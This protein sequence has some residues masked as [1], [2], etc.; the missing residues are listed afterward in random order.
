[1]TGTPRSPTDQK[2]KLIGAALVLAAGGVLA[3]AWWDLC[4]PD[5][6]VQWLHG[7]RVYAFYCRQLVLMALGISLACLGIWAYGT[8]RRATPPTQG[9]LAFLPAL[10]A[11]GFF[12]RYWLHPLGVQ[13]GS[14]AWAYWLIAVTALSLAR[15]LA[16]L[17]PTRIPR[18]HARAVLYTLIALYIATFGF[19]SIARHTTF[20]SHALDLGT[21]DQAIWNTIHGR[22]LERTPLYRHPA[23]G[24]RYESRLSDGK[25]EL[26]LIPLSALYL[27]WPDPRLL[28]AV[29]T[30][31]LAMGAV[32]L[33]LLAKGKGTAGD[34]HRWTA[35]LLAAAYLVYLPLHYINLADF[36]P[37]ALMVPL[38]IA[39][40][41]ATRRQRWQWY[42]T[43]LLLAFLCRVDAAFAALGVG[44]ALMLRGRNARKYGLYTIVA[45]TAWLTLDLGVVTPWA[46]QLYGPGAGSLIA[47]RFGNLPG[48]D[49]R[50][51]ATRLL[52]RESLQTIFD[53]LAP[54]GFVAVLAPS[55]L[56]PALPMLVINLLAGSEWQRSIHAHYMAAV[57][58]FVWIAVGEAMPRITRRF[59]LATK[60]IAVLVL[61]CSFLAAV[62]FSPFPPG[63]QFHLLEW[64]IH[65]ERLQ[66][67]IT[68]I[69]DD[70]SMC[71]QSD[72][73]P[74]LSQRRDALLF[75]F[76]RLTDGEEA[77]FVILDLDPSSVKSPLD[78]HAFYDLADT[79]LQRDDYGVVAWWNGALLLRRGW[80]SVGYEEMR[81]ARDEYGRE[82]YRA[83]FVN[84]TIPD[85]LRA[86][87]L[88]RFSIKLR[89]VGSGCWSAEGQL[90]VRLTYR[91][92]R[93]NEPLP[94]SKSMRTDM[95]HRV[96]P[97]HT[98]RLRAWVLTPPSPGQYTFEWDLVREGDAWFSS[99]GNPTWRQAVTVH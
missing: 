53:L 29:Q 44:A 22:L 38:L 48:S 26:V 35:L 39:A 67:L 93:G 40:W 78:Y 42:A 87:E 63:R 69:P 66:A 89:N 95:P 98:V 76:C 46:R 74:H 1:M 24:S 65:E 9:A 56:L 55:A 21:M 88:Y 6:F 16:N 25:L 31:L 8:W 3:L 85:R 50:E 2:G 37:S 94:D 57:V 13:P 17:L 20:R 71:A 49:W 91:W 23:D 12:A 4:Y 45:A 7:R 77:E 62:V 58:P 86:A 79:W 47:R 51:I 84:A 36:H 32:P 73:Y 96:A 70:T 97:G 27:L 83:E 90:P 80:A 18:R 81:Q 11:I 99:R 92:W 52:N 10:G 33:Y 5:Q 59:P 82:F 15:P 61:L 14:S 68:L 75:P 43:W 64:T 19:L 28:L 54:V 41:Q 30:V 34:D 60:E 72:I